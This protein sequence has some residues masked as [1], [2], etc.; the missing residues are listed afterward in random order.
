MPSTYS[1]RSRGRPLGIT[2]LCILG[3]IGAFFSFFGMFGVMGRGGPFAIIG[4]VGLA[5]VAGKAAVLY[6]LW[7]LQY[8]GYKWALRLYALSAV[9]DLVT[10]SLFALVIDVLIVAYIAS[11]VDHFR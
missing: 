8:W 3:F 11:K 7:T 1:S 4:L 2:I 10:L 5:L 6:G 9:L